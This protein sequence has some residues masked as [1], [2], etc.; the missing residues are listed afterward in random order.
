MNTEN[1]V[2]SKEVLNLIE[3]NREHLNAIKRNCG[4]PEDADLDAEIIILCLLARRS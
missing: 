2:N 3:Q 1:T 4:V